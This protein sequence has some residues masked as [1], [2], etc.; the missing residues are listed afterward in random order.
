MT[1]SAYDD[2]INKWATFYGIPAALV[3]AVV[4]QE[5]TFNASANNPE[6]PSWGLMGV[7]SGTADFV[8]R[9]FGFKPASHW[10]DTADANVQIGAGYLK[11]QLD[12]YNGNVPNAVAAYNSGTVKTK[13]DGSYI[14]QKYVD[15][16][17]GWFSQYSGTSTPPSTP[18]AG[19][20]DYTPGGSGTGDGGDALKTIFIASAGLLA[21]LMLRRLL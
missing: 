10:Q 14:N 16:V 9:L 11:Y 21:V 6:D 4:R 7:M 19:P 8:G 12:R 2:I 3:K 5:S 18:V 13:K 17:L 15:D 1:S 20:S